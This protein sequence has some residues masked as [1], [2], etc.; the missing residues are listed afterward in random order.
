MRE[1]FGKKRAQ[2]GFFSL[3]CDRRPPAMRGCKCSM[4]ATTRP[5]LCTHCLEK[6]SS[7]SRSTAIPCICFIFRLN[8]SKSWSGLWLE[9]NELLSQVLMPSF[10]LSLTVSFTL[11]LL[12]FFLDLFLFLLLLFKVCSFDKSTNSSFLSI[13]FETSISDW[14]SLWSSS[15]NK[16]LLFS[17]YWLTVEQLS[18]LSSIEIKT[19]WAQLWAQEA[20][21]F[22]L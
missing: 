13:L 11:D 3:I 21:G 22:R 12:F 9:V 1:S 2:F 17:L 8:S 15:V 10:F 4:M 6:G 7:V 5:V 20:M 19:V 18:S 16:Y 14:V